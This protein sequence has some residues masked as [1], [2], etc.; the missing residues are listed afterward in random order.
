[1]ADYSVVQIDKT[2]NHVNIYAVYN[3]SPDN[4]VCIKMKRNEYNNK[5]PN[6]ITTIIEDALKKSKNNDTSVDTNEFEMTMLNNCIAN[7]ST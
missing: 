6:E 2:A 3:D 7:K 4:K 5:T 1:M